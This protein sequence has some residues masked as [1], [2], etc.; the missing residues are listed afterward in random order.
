MGLYGQLG[1][2]TTGDPDNHVRL[3]PVRVRRS[4]STFTGVRTLD[5]GVYHTCALRTNRSV[6]C[7]GLNSDGQLGRGTFDDD[8]HPFPGRVTFP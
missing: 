7:W 2:G 6:W 5:G 1:D 3:K 8:T 4:V